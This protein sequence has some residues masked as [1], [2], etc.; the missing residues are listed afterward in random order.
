MCSEARNRQQRSSRTE[1]DRCAGLQIISKVCCFPRAECPQHDI[2]I[3]YSYG[4]CC[5]VDTPKLARKA[6]RQQL[7]F[8][9]RSQ[10]SSELKDWE[11]CF[12]RKRKRNR[13]CTHLLTLQTS[14]SA[15]CFF[16]IGFFVIE[17]TVSL[18]CYNPHYIGC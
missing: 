14:A 4:I 11:I 5:R 16:F 10:L 1:Y 7:Q 6:H 3:V 15:L 13:R 9:V 8:F 18:L 2:N 12:V 17:C